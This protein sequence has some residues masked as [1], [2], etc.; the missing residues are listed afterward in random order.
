MPAMWFS[1]TRQKSMAICLAILSL[2]PAIICGQSPSEKQIIEE[3]QKLN[4]RLD[5]IEKKLDEKPPLVSSH[6]DPEKKIFGM[7]FSR[8]PKGNRV[9]AVMQGSPADKAGVRPGELLSAI[10][11][12]SVIALTGAELLQELDKKDSY[13]FNF[14]SKNGEKRQATITKSR[15]GDFM[16]GRGGYVLSG[17]H[18]SLSEVDVGQVAPEITAKDA[19][20]KDVKLSS[21]KGKVVLVNFTATW[22][23]PCKKELPDLIALRQKYYD[24]GFEVISVFL[25]SDRTAVE[26]HLKENGISWL[27]AF[28]GKG[29]DNQVAREWGISGVPTNPIIDKTGV[30][31]KANVRGNEIE[32]A[33]AKY[34][35]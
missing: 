9:M 30:V 18:P 6:F 11:G 20:G 24:Q 29:W 1:M 4:Q 28:D 19:D 33:V 12:N 7:Q 8:G 13:V 10:D 27:Y 2:C 16:D 26:R 15:Q 21:L 25:D 17:E 34:L 35:K 22:C 31:V 3:L 5:K 23:G 14:E 32:P